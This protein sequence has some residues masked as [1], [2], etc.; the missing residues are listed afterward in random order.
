MAYISSRPQYVKQDQKFVIVQPLQIVSRTPA[1]IYV[2]LPIL[3][4]RHSLS[5]TYELISPT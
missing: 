2:V 3:R 1:D 4:H 5:P